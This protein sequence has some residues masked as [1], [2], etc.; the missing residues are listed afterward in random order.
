MNDTNNANEILEATGQ[1]L[2]RVFFMGMFSLLLWWIA[3]LFAG[4]LAYSVHSRM[5]PISR[6]HFDVIHYAGM[7]FTKGVIVVFFL[8][9]YIGIRLVIKKNR[10]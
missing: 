2:I 10:S 3:L 6:Q 1:V 4:D 5:V 8:F 9:P 7:L